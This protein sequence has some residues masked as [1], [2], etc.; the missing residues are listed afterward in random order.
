MCGNAWPRTASSASIASSRTCKACPAAGPA[1]A[2]FGAWFHYLAP[3]LAG[4]DLGK[5]L[6]DRYAERF[7]FVT[8]FV[9]RTLSTNDSS[10]CDDK[11][12]A[13]QETCDDAVTHALRTAVADLTG[14]MGSDM[15]RWRWDA[16]HRAVFPHQG[17]DAVKALRPILSRSVAYFEAS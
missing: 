5:P 17:L 1:A 15:S 12:T 7:T 8:R 11:A 2:I 9:M 10:W 14:R 13:A 3:V 6:A 16:V 4:D